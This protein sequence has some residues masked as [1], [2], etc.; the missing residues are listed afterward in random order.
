MSGNYGLRDEFKKTVFRIFAKENLPID[1]VLF[2]DEI[3]MDVRH[4]SKV[5]YNLLRQKIHGIS[6]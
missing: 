1:D 2:M 3:P 5:E 4:H 6:E